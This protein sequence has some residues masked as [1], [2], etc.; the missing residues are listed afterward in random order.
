MTE[1]IKCSKCKCEQL[2]TEDNFS[3][4]RKGT[5]NKT[6]IRCSERKKIN[7]IKNKC[8]H[9]KNKQNC[10]DCK[11]S[12]ICEHDNFRYS[13]RE[14]R[15]A[16][17]CEHD[18]IR[19]T[20]KDCKGGGLCIHDKVRSTCIDCK[21]GGLCV[22][23]KVRSRCKECKGSGICEH[24]KFRY[25]CK[26]CGGG[27]ICEHNKAKY[28]CKICKGAGICEHNKIKA[29]CI[30]CTVPC[31][32]GKTK[33]L[34]KECKGGKKECEHGK[35]K[36]FCKICDPL[37][38]LRA[39]ISTLTHNALKTYIFQKT[40]RYLGC[41]TQKIKEHLEKF[42]NDDNGFTWE[43]HG[44]LWHIDHIKPIKYDNPSLEEVMNRLHYTNLQPLLKEDNIIKGNRRDDTSE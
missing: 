43:N 18:K 3:K 9:N 24:N 22:H 2:L 33:H 26:E 21:G 13:C 27:G 8:E 40:E 37:G 10:K 32:H 1:I 4:N 34:C 14:C 6:C 25:S 11:G 44:D 29:Y 12:G 15:G 36:Y 41:G 5:F 42:F 39:S 23:G 28:L 20:C 7:V 17:I 19:S 30:E 31:E 38:H 16:G 35:I